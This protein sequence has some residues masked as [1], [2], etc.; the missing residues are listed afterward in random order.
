MID[1]KAKRYIL[2]NMWRLRK[3]YSSGSAMSLRLFGK[4]ITTAGQKVAE[5]KEPLIQIPESDITIGK[6]EGNEGEGNDSQ[7]QFAS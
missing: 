7:L 2:Q 5:H 6:P 4:D 3:V 1:K